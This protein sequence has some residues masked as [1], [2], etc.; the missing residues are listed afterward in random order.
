MSTELIT[1]PPPTETG[2]LN[3]AANEEIRL[4]LQGFLSKL[5]SAPAPES[6]D[7][8]ADGKANTILISHIETT[9]DEYF[10][11]LWCTE[12]MRIQIVGNEIV[13]MM[14]LKVLHPTAGIWITRQGAASITI[15]VDAV[16]ESLKW[17]Q[18]DSKEVADLK[19]KQ[20]N[21]WA[22]DMENKKSNALDMGFPKLKAELLKNAANS[23]GKMFGRDLNR[24]KQDVYQP[25]IK[26]SYKPQPNDE[27]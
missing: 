18:G 9:L 1:Q 27:Q 2:V 7:K 12:N 4:K 26:K 16:P 11:G 21:A 6:I 23:L 14:D 24:K 15:M 22:L 8:T 10:F 20:R 17:A 3:T 13:G 19:A 25:L 5:N